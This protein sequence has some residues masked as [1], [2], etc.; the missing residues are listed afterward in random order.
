MK[1]TAKCSVWI[2]L[3]G[4]I[5]AGMMPSTA[6]VYAQ[7]V[8]QISPDELKNMIES[9]K[10]DFLVVDVQPKVVYDTG[11]IKG[12]VSFPWA[13]NIRR[14]ASLPKD[15]M[16]V[17]YCDCTHE[18]DSTSTATQLKEK[19]GYTNVRVLK[20][21]WSGWLKLGYPIEKK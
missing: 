15:K 19:F 10:N 4:L 3:I 13:A 16:L 1:N 14:A 20:G 18:E 5:L 11:H 6:I 17:L 9:K 7:D 2:I 21:G 12:A 8:A